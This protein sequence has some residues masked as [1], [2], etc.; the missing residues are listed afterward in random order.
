MIATRQLRKLG[1]ARYVV[2]GIPRQRFEREDLQ[3][4]GKRG[5]QRP[6]MAAQPEDNDGTEDAVSRLASKRTSRR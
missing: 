3:L 2:Q 6:G 5:A 1:F 4:I